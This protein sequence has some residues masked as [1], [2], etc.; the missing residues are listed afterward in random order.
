MNRIREM[1]KW[2]NPLYQIDEGHYHVDTKEY[3]QAVFHYSIALGEFVVA[4]GTLY[5]IG[6]YSK[7][8]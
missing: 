5:M 6:K 4:L 3:A 8:P 2:V 7:L 1:I